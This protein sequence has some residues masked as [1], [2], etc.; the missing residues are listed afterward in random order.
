LNLSGIHAILCWLV[1]VAPEWGP[2]FWWFGRQ[3]VD[4]MERPYNVLLG[5]SKLLTTTLVESHDSDDYP[6]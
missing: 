5:Q 2:F 3:G 1:E 4:F 6:V